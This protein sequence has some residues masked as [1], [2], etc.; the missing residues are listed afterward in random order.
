MPIAVAQH[1]FGHGRGLHSIAAVALGRGV[2]AGLVANGRPA[3]RRRAAAPASSATISSSADG[4]ANAAA[5]AASRP[6]AADSGMLR[7][8]G[9]RDPSAAGKSIDDLAAAVAAGDPAAR[10]V[11]EEAAQRLGRH[12]ATLV[13]VFDPE[14]I[15]FGGEGV[16]FGRHLFDPIRKVLDEVCYPGRA[17]DRDRLGE[18]RAGSAAPRRSPIQHF[19]N[20]EA[21][22]GYTPKNSRQK[23]SRSR[24]VNQRLQ[25]AEQS[26]RASRK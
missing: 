20:F 17:A 24:R 4:A 11:L 8:W 6:V 5:T 7:S 12:V 21:T 15:V 3:S 1:L 14:M 2:G 13:N 25:D 26:R 19:F 22:G 9:E 10:A 23:V 18:E 16:R